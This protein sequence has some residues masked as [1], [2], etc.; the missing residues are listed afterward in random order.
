MQV[1]SHAQL[2]EHGGR[3]RSGDVGQL[4]IERSV[5]CVVLERPPYATLPRGTTHCTD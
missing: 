4:R 1:T 3:D 2:C 5:G